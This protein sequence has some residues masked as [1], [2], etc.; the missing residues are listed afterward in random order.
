[1]QG[2]LS[3]V[4]QESV[5]QQLESISR[6][7][8]VIE[9]LLFLARSEVRAI[10]L[11]LKNQ[12]TAALIKA[13]SEDAMVLCEEAKVE[14]AIAQNIETQ[15]TFDAALLRQ[16]LLNLLS[17]AIRFTPIGGR[18]T[19]SSCDPGESVDGLD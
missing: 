19:L 3:S 10:N 17:N 15:A 12:S 9:K 16:V 14:F 1:M 6:L 18:I 13:F 4:Q 7:T 11:N 8:V 5:H 2:A